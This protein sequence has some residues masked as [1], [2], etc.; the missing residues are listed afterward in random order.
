M[1]VIQYNLFFLI[2][3]EFCV[4]WSFRIVLHYVVDFRDFMSKN[5]LILYFLGLG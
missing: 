1:I 5:D 3:E 2:G 4:D